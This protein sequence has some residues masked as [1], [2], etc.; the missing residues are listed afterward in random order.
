MIETSIRS[1]QKIPFPASLLLRFFF[2]LHVPQ[3]LGLKENNYRLQY[4][5]LTIFYKVWIYR[6]GGGGGV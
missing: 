2:V 3:G 1:Y 5:I 4:A 6:G